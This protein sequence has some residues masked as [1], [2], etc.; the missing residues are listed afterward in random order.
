[1]RS[2]VIVLGLCFA[3][4]AGAE[5]AGPQLAGHGCD[6]VPPHATIYA[7]EESDFPFCESIVRE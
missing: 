2:V 6:G 1:M 3:F 4:F 5:M 7:Y